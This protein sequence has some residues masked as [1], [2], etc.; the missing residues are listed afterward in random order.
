[1]TNARLHQLVG[2]ALGLICQAWAR[3]GKRPGFTGPGCQRYVPS[4][5][6]R[7][8]DSGHRKDTSAITGGLDTHAD[9]HVA[10]ALDPV[11]GLLGV[12]EFPATPAGYAQ[13]PTPGRRLLRS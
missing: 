8:D 9:M 6:L 12:Q 4:V 1:M 13:K 7:R 3:G 2:A 11:G 5:N 10:A